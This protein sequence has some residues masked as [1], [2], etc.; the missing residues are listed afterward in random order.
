MRDSLLN[1]VQGRKRSAAWYLL[2]I[3]V[4]VIGGIIGY[5]AVRH[6]DPSLAKKLLYVGIGI[7]ATGI[8]ITVVGGF[9]MPD[10]FYSVPSI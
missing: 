8:I 6:D 5:F 2:P 4:G 7:T 1:I 3:F 10:E 9:F